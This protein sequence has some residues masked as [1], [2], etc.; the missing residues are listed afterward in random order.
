MLV[1]VIMID[2]GQGMYWVKKALK[3]TNFRKHDTH[4][5]KIVY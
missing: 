2:E 5:I 1:I 3:D 4:P